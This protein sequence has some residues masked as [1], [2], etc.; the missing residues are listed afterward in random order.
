MNTGSP[1][2]RARD[3]EARGRSVEPSPESAGR[4]PWIVDALREVEEIHLAVAE[5]ALPEIEPGTKTNVANLLR[6]IARRGVRTAPIVCPTESGEVAVY[7]HSR[8]ADCAIL[9]DIGNDGRGSF[10]CVP[11]RFADRCAH[12]GDAADLPRDRSLQE[13]PD[14][15]DPGNRAARR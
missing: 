1:E 6:A 10:V 5:D 11:D 13:C 4:S 12:A 14:R 8:A 7:F 15:L 9:I 3:A 2:E